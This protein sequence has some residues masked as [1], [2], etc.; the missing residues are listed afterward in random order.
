MNNKISSKKQSNQKKAKRQQPRKD[1]PSKRVN[2]DN[3]RVDK[4]DKDIKDIS[5]TSKSN[6]VSWYAN[7]AELLRSAASLP[8]STVTGGAIPYW[9]PPGADGPK[10]VPGIMSFNWIPS[11]GG[12]FNDA[13][14]AAKDSI[15]SFT[16]H[17]NS[18]NTTYSASDEMLVILAGAQLFSWLAFGIRAYGVA[19]LFDQ[20]N[21]YLPDGLLTAMGFNPEDIRQHLSN[22]W[23]DLNEMIARSSQIW[24]PNTLPVLERW[25][26]MNSN[27]YMDGTAAKSQYYLFV[28]E[29]A[30]IYDETYNDEGGAVEIL[31]I[32]QGSTNHTWMGSGTL[33]TWSEYVAYTNQLFDALIN[34]EDRGIIFGDILKAYGSERIYAL[35][36]IPVDYTVIP[37]YDTEVL[38]QI[39]NITQTSNYAEAI[40]QNQDNQRLYSVYLPPNP[41]ST[42]FDG[43]WRPD[44]TILNFHQKE[45]P[46]PEQIMVATRLKAMGSTPI[47]GSTAG[48]I[49]QLI[50]TTC[51]TEVVT[52][53]HAFWYDSSNNLRNNYVPQF[54]RPTTMTVAMAEWFSFA[55][56]DWSPFYYNC[57]S[58]NAPSTTTDI[59]A[60]QPKR[61]YFAIGDYDQWTTIDVATVS[62]MHQTAIYSEFGVPAM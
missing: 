42:N 2:F 49:G 11:I 17:A 38:T 58:T 45:V 4:F 15:Y 36:P 29:A 37:V 23:F 39:E 34:S 52:S 62:K 57:D 60:Y 50:T 19:K 33:H 24:I 51:G 22:M 8:F 56:F 48:K 30:W 53:I 14:N 32:A 28:P 61:T 18:R 25:F 3:T 31:R 54:I 6:D 40:A 46:S 55:S 5:K 59:S 47:E 7:N 10:S 35:K 13:I 16:V 12:E 20:R 21:H 41:P 1:S 9:N 27:I 26:W 44:V 43:Q